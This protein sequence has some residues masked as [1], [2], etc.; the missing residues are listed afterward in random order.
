MANFFFNCNQICWFM[1][2][3]FPVLTA[4]CLLAKKKKKKD[5]SS[6]A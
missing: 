1:R 6:F 2:N 4:N 5:Y 3:Y